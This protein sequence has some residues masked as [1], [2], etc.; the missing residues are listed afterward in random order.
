M[1][2]T[3]YIGLILVIIIFGIIFIP[4][5]VSRI[6]NRKIV[7]SNRSQSSIPLQYVFLNGEAKKVPE[8][9]FLNQ[10]SII[11]SNEDFSKK[12]YVAEFFFTS[13]PSIC[14]IMNKNMKRI[15]NRF[16]K[17]QD[18]GIASFSIDP[19]KDTPSV[20]K[21]YAETYDVFSQNW[22]FLTGEKDKIYNLANEGFNIFASVNPR[23]AGGFE[24]QGYFALID[25][26]GFIRCRSDQFGNPIVYYMG[27]DEEDVEI[28]EVDLL[29]D[30][31]EKLLKE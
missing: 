12:V 19:I 29:I 3:K 21:E 30:D 28:Q 6:T 2:N 10:D 25:K 8:F 24:H 20:L 31:I 17:R 15:E 4:K 26:N 5:I 1:R 9:A 14:P 11:I 16:G 23:V 18:F 27:V 13:C 22:H 7:E